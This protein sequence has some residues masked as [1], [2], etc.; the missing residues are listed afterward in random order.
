MHSGASN[1]I[2]VYTDGTMVY[3]TMQ[4]TFTMNANA[5]TNTGTIPSNYAPNE[6][7]T[8]PAH[9]SSNNKLSIDIDGSL[10]YHNNTSNT[11][12]ILRIGVV[13]PLKTALP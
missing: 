10:K 3:L 4:G 2:K 5:D 1:R 13:Y 11:N 9:Y 12:Q 8:V 6:I 7:I